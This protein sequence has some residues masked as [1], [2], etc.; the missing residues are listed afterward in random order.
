MWRCLA[1]AA[2]VP[3]VLATPANAWIAQKTAAPAPGTS[4]VLLT[5]ASATLNSL[6]ER[7]LPVGYS[8][9][10][11]ATE[12]LYGVVPAPGA[13]TGI[14]MYVNTAPTGS[15]EWDVVLRNNGVD[16]ALTCKITSATSAKCTGTGSVAFAAG[17][18]PSLV[19][20][21]T[22]NPSASRGSISLVFA[23]A[24]A[25]DTILMAQ[26]VGANNT[27]EQAVT[28]F[29]NGAPGLALNRRDNAFP[30][31]GTIDL[32]HVVSNAPGAGTSYAYAVNRN[33]VTTT[34]QVNCPIADTATS[35]NDASDSFSVTG[36]SGSTAGDDLQ[37]VMT[38]AGSPAVPTAGYGARYRP[39]TAG[40]FALM[41]GRP[42]L[43][44]T[45]D[46]M[47][48]PLTAGGTGGSTT[49]VNNHGIS[50]AQTITRI[51][52]K[53]SAAPG[54]GKSRLFTLRR[55]GAD[56]GCTVTVSDTAT[57][58]TAACSITVADDDLLG[59]SD[60]PT[61]T[62]TAAIPSISYLANR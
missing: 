34:P 61:A 24:A 46:V 40:S 54:A 16:T 4:Q 13:F 19:V 43:N 39:T 31:G 27:T 45:T 36:P 1:P 38:P 30:D 8:A 9:A 60:A 48:Y 33:A 62:P 11:A 44:S 55:N 2:L 7:F 15:G 58:N 50:H 6:T 18:R 32:L 14:R 51:A 52:V 3:A 21:P 56:T 59:T 26:L 28:P 53:L 25:N 10:P 57:A 41:T 47:Y 29:S 12:T 49:E 42:A 37:F 22:G 20:R 17:D 35:C 23:P 5:T